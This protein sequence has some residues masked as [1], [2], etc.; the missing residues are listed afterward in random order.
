MER[1][2]VHGG[3]LANPLLFQLNWNSSNTTGYINWSINDLTPNEERY[4]VAVWKVK[5]LK[6]QPVLEN[7]TPSFS[8]N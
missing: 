4:I 6:T 3:F 5:Q 2:I 1:Q 7:V 8:L